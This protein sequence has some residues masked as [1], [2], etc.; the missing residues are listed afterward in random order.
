M[1]QCPYVTNSNVTFSHIRHGLDPY[2]SIFC[3]FIFN[4]RGKKRRHFT[5][6]YG[7]H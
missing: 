2:K 6:D 5:L 4:D 7:K 3:C 1:S